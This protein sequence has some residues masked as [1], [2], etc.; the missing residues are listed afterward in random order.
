MSGAGPIPS[1]RATLPRPSPTGLGS[2]VALLAVLGAATASLIHLRINVATLVDSAGLCA[3]FV[4]RMLPLDFPPVA[5]ILTLTGQTLS[6]VVCATLLSAVLSLPV[7]VLA[8]TNTTLNTTTRMVARAVIVLARALPD[9][10]LVIVAFRVFGLGGI[11]AVLAMAIHSV[12]MI[13]KLFTDAV[14]DIDDGVRTAVRVTGAS[15]TQQ[16]VAGVLP[17]V[18]PSFVATV[19]HRLDINLRISVVLG[20]VGVAGLGAEIAHA[21]QRLDYPRGMA[22]ALVVF[23][24]CVVMEVVSGSVR[25]VLLPPRARRFAGRGRST[26]AP[27]APTAAT[28]PDGSAPL[29][30]DAARP[31]R[32][33][34][35][36]LRVNWRGTA[37][38]V[39]AAVLVLACARGA[40][41]SL[42]QILDGRHHLLPVLDQFLPPSSGGIMGDL[43]DA[44]WTTT[45]IALGGTLLGFALAL[46]CGV[47]AA[48]NLAPSPTVAFLSRGLI[49]AIRGVPELILAIVFVIATGLGPVAG[50]LALGLGSVGFLGKLVADTLEEL[51]PGPR[52]ALLALGATPVQAFFAATLRQALPALVA[53]VLHQLDVNV[54]SATLL[55]IVG[56][57]GIG[58]YL[59]NASRVQEFGVVAT[60]ILMVLGVVLT[61]EGLAVWLRRVLS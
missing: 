55:G 9:L 46:P 35:E 15:R 3:D 49:L 59:I 36:T 54:R 5:E 19:L 39:V 26:Q 21:I 6:I 33:K 7:A 18:L 52:T 45:Q 12:G 31:G 60:I 14:E 41:L 27:V 4:R 16:F 29:K 24:L 38:T 30:A 40:D 57:G 34:R 51:D 47:L 58:Y 28:L 48:R 22:L 10:V 8:A 32:R 25:R 1:R 43:L 2:A 50:T 23:V 20:F 44:L 13:G 61:I 11:G 53:H 37:L 42:Q 17:Q 56:A